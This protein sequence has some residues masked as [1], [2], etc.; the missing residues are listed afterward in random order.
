MKE[1]SVYHSLSPSIAEILGS[2]GYDRPTE[3]Q[4]RAIP[5][6]LEGKNVLLIAPSGSGKTEAALLPVFDG[7][8]GVRKERGIKVYVDF[9]MFLNVDFTY[10]GGRL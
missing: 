6:I 5:S 3:P 8:L 10:I 9:Y 7:L 1:V 4:S 2:L